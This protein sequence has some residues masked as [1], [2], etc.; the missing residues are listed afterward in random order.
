MDLFLGKWILKKDV[1]FENFLKFTEVPWIQRRFAEHNKITLVIEKWN[2]SYI[3]SVTSPFYNVEEIIKLDNQY[4]EYD[5]SFKKFRIEENI[6]YI[7]I[8]YNTG[9]FWKEEVYIKDGFLISKY[10]WI[11][12]NDRKLAVQIF[13]RK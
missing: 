5:K 9:I 2:K 7:D 11:K 10:I 8:R 1:H 6:I 12:D 4:R 3:K 13:E